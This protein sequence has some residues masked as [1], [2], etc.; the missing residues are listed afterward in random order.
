M[1]AYR[2]A[3]L[4]DIH[5]SLTAL[6][7]V[8][9]AV[10]QFAPLDAILVAG[11]FT[12]GPNQP[13]TITRMRESRV[14]AIRGNADIDLLNFADGKSPDFMYTLKQFSLIRWSLDNTTSESLDFLRDLPEQRV[15]TLPGVDPIRLVHGSPRD[16]NESLD[17]E[18]HP[19]LLGEVLKA[20]SEPILVFGHTHRPLIKTQDGRLAL[21]PGAV[22]MAVGMPATAYFAILEW[23]VSAD[24]WQ[25]HLHHVSYNP[26]ELMNEFADSSLLDIS[27]LGQLILATSLTGKNVGLKYMQ[28]ALTLAKASGCGD[29][30]YIPDALWEEAAKTYSSY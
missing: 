11:D 19:T 5:A 29:L 23:P 17:A 13:A 3:V 1:V 25:A 10:E 9:G 15:V 28:Y 16:I 22:S 6:D 8:L 26:Q 30:P 21:N 20:L 4:S 27:P 7:V 18:K 2:I 12:Y 24:H 14:I